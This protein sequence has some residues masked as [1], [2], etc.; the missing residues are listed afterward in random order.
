MD[1]KGRQSQK[2]ITRN[3]RYSPRKVSQDASDPSQFNLAGPWGPPGI[4]TVREMELDNQ[5]SQT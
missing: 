5:V 2:R 1:T 3:L 4:A